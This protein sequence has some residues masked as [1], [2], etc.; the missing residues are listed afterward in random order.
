MADILSRL[1]T[2]TTFL[3]N[4]ID[5][6][7]KGEIKIPQFQRK[8]VWKEQQALDLLDSIANNY[9]IGSL[10]LWRTQVKL[11]TER[12]IGD[13]RLPET[14]DLTPTDYVLDGQQRITV[15]Y[16]CLGA[17]DTETGFA[18]VFDLQ[19]N[20]FQP[21]PDQH[22]ALS[23]PLRWLYETTKLLDFRT[24]LKTYPDHE[25]YQTRLDALIAAF[26]N[27][28]LPVVTLKDLSIEEVCPIF[29]RINSSGT[30]LSTYDLMVAATWSQ[31]FDLNDETGKIATALEPKGFGTIDP[32][33]LL[34]C[35]AA[36]KF[37]S[38][39]KDDILALRNVADE[40]DALVDDTSSALLKAVDLLS[41]EFR[42]HSWDFLPYE[43]LLIVIT[44]AFS[45]AHGLSTDQLKRIRIWF[46]RA[47]FAERYRVG[48]ENF[49]TNDLKVVLNFVTEG[50][51]D[52]ADLG[53]PPSREQVANTIF[54][55][56]NSRARAFVLSLAV[57]RPRNITNGASIDTAEALSIFNKKQFHHVFPRAHLRRI[58]APEEHNSIIN[59]CMLTASE[60]NSISDDDPKEYV[61]ECVAKL[62]DSAD[63]V[64]QSNLLPPPSDFDYTIRTYADFLASRS[65]IV[66]E[67][68]AR[69]CEG[70]IH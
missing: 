55:I 24:G 54:R 37:A 41:T 6:V 7:K 15:I 23:F 48:G 52:S 59:I 10:L 16:S 11:A 64:F 58:E 22:N 3:K 21:K 26:T 51:G 32:N 61:P 35:L 5:D 30:K 39:K 42:I 47:A 43:A 60:N 68:I 1:Q 66:S 56:N 70:D 13:F 69:L 67:Y 19:K 62:G 20:V 46:W 31:T 12:N 49:V 50:L 44:Y 9:P 27:Y 18:V 4:I 34:K 38:I 17:P 28:K 63:A 45:K 40:M 8:F 36:V 53:V 14:D 57:R 2:D 33:T 65:A 29:E 25:T